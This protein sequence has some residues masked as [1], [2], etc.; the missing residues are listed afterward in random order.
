MSGRD[1]K[2]T[3]GYDNTSRAEQARANRHRVLRA[4]YRL[5]ITTGYAAT[6]IKA[7]AAE[8][9]VSA[10]TVYKSFG[11]KAKLI[12]ETYDVTLVGDE[13]PI[14][15][16][17]RPE[18]QALIADPSARGKLTAYA[19]LCRML[20]ARLGPLIDVLL[21][22]AKSGDHEL[23]EFA[24]TIKRER[25]LG[26]T[27]IVRQIVGTGQARAD[28]DQDRA[29]DMVWVL[30]SPEVYQLLSRDRGWTDDQ[31]EQWLGDM[32]IAEMLDDDAG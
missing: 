28:L 4:T 11:S 23:A 6:T 20:S 17:E 9:G 30:N 16:M 26:A 25:L 21:A 22:G 8:A 1:V 5:L 7:V 13:E 29:R 10:E 24:E 14:P 2:G 3:R 19:G 32:F 15:F 18:Y 12:K 31:Y 27:E